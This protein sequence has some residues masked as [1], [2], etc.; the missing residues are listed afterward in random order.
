MIGRRIIAVAALALLLAAPAASRADEP[1]TLDRAIDY[2]LVN[3][4]DLAVYAADVRTAEQVSKQVFGNYLPQLALEGGYQ[5]LGNVPTITV[6]IKLPE[7]LPIDLD[8]PPMKMEMGSHDNYQAQ[9]KLDQLL[10]GSGR[11]FYGHR[12]A[13]SQ[14]DGRQAQYRTAQLK[15]AQLTAEAFLGLL[16]TGENLDAR[17]QALDAAQQHLDQVTNRHEAG[18]ASRYELLRAQVEVN[19][20]EPQ[21]HEAQEMLDLAQSGFRRALGLPE[22]A[23]VLVAGSL[24]TDVAPLSEESALQS[25]LV[26]RPEFELIDAGVRAYEDL[27]RSRRAQMLPALMF[28]GSYGYSKPYY[29]DKEGDLNWSVGLG[30]RVPIFDGLRSWHEAGES[31]AQAHSLRMARTRLRAD[32]DNEL[33]SAELSRREAELRVR[34]TSRTVE[35]AESMVQ[36]AEQS[37]TAGALTSL[38]VI[39]AQLA[40][41]NARLL[42]LKALYDYRLSQVR[43]AAAGGDLEMI[44]RLSQ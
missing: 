4:P 17:Q 6:K 31:R 11:V 5:Y 29:F 16:I 12:A 40:L 26:N 28:S 7:D 43:L 9:F 2:A 35:T 33:R 14:V 37:Y 18:A 44:R 3:N 20:L 10:F 22:D 27:A 30:L 1:W 24:Q 41:T 42:H 21:V 13:R 23:S 25:A 15:V 34:S 39:D 32:V 36:I 38:D 19:N 8:I